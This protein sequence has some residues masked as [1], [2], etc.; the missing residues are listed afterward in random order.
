MKWHKIN[1]SRSQLS[2]DTIYY[3]KIECEHDGDIQHEIIELEE[4]GA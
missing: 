3:Y 2:K 1:E 4:I